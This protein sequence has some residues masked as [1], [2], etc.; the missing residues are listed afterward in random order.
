MNVGQEEV[1]RPWLVREEVRDGFLIG[2]HSVDHPDLV[3]LPASKQATEV[4]GVIHLDRSIA[5]TSPCV[6][7]PPYGD[8]D[9]A[10]LSLANSRH[11]TLWMWSVDTDDWQA[12]GSGSS[13]WV[14]RIISTAE[15]E[16]IALRHPVV[17]MHNQSIPMP[18]T[19]AA[20]PTII[21]F[22]EQHHY[23]F[24]DLL[25]R[26]GPPGSCGR[27]PASRV[28]G[29]AL[30]AGSSLHPGR[31]LTAP[32]GQFVLQMQSDGDLVA[33]V[34][35][36]PVVWSSR[37]EGN[38]GASLTVERSG[39]VKV[40]SSSGKV[41]W[42]TRTG[43]HRGARFVLGVNGDLWVEGAGHQ[44]WTS[45]SAITTL[46]AGDML[47]PGWQLSSPNGRCTLIQRRSGALVLATS[48]GEELWSSGTS[49][50]PG[51][52]TIAI[53]NGNVETRSDRGAIVWESYTGQHGSTRL[54][55]LDSGQ[56]MISTNKG[57]RLW[58]SP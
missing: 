55:V 9:D 48:A 10:V 30:S 19:V 12:E 54:Q 53:A 17:L 52:R 26:S 51:A 40:V 34:K 38:S 13:T 31:S 49:H 50:D 42:S 8:Y 36:G 27:Q 11:L 7:R 16:G 21:Q 44:L 22:F 41:L 3:P 46:H 35:G 23:T 57:A 25:G 1:Y 47:Q 32:N 15:S 18:A 56:L 45:D 43:G 2:D 58:I 5:A 24:V 28:E 33:H 4:D 14:H 39:N 29:V 20:L 37:T 6:F